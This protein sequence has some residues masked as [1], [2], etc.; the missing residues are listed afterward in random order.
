[1]LAEAL[2]TRA[3]LTQA[4]L[5]QALLT[6]ALLAEALLTEALP[7]QHGGVLQ[8]RLVLQHSD[9]LWHDRQQLPHHFV[10]ILLAQLPRRLAEGRV[11][12][13]ENQR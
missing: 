10:D 5:T 12:T 8:L 11:T 13:E 2:L 3:L 4:L 9:D 7:A 1:M 6:E